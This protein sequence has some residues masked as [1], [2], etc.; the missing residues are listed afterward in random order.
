[1]RMH[2]CIVMIMMVTIGGLVAQKRPQAE[3]R[4]WPVRLEFA[5]PLD[6]NNSC[7]LACDLHLFPQSSPYRHETPS[8]SITA[9][10][11]PR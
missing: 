4:L 9:L 1:M 2:T 3:V 7:L 10:M 8:M 11:R 5:I 6:A